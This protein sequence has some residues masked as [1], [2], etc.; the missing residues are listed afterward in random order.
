M[1]KSSSKSEAK[2]QI[3]EFFA[4]SKNKTSKQVKKIKRLAMSQN[5]P[6]KEKRKLFCKKC[7]VVY[8][9]PKI[10]IKKGIKSITCEN[11]NYTSRWKINN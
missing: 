11:C 4:N 10:R 7:L 9:T 2:K 6:L 8:K 5:I 1:K 3:E